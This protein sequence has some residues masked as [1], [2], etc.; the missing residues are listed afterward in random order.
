[1]KEVLKPC[2]FCGNSAELRSDGVFSYVI[3][4]KCGASTEFVKVS[5]EYCSDENAV[6]NWNRRCY[7]SD[8]L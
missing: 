4:K 8:K 6:F 5:H 1:M 2:P 7:S 3:C